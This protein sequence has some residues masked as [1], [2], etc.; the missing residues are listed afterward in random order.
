MT[1]YFPD[2]LPQ[3]L[4]LGVFFSVGL[5]ATPSPANAGIIVQSKAVS[6]NPVW[7]GNIQGYDHT[8]VVF[9]PFDDA[10]GTRTL[11]GMNWSFELIGSIQ[12]TLAPWGDTNFSV[13]NQELGASASRPATNADVAATVSMGSS[14]MFPGNLNLFCLD[15]DSCSKGSPISFA[16]GGSTSV[17][18]ELTFLAGGP[19]FGFDWYYTTW[20]DNDPDFAEAHV[21]ASAYGG[22]SVEYIYDEANPAPE[23]GTLLLLALGFAGLGAVR[24]RARI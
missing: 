12:V 15:G 6:L 4:L 18:S 20:M 16:G 11:T 22:V 7:D 19:A 2:V 5:L 10:G 24:Q 21:Y 3:R 1:R 13:L 17:P 14:T 9:D 8:W 23:P